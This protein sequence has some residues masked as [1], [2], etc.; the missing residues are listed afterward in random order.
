MPTLDLRSPAFDEGAAIPSRFTCDGEDT[1]PPL[2]ASPGPQ[3]TESY[4]LVFDDPDAPGGTWVHW[5]VWNLTTP[6]LPE[7]ASGAALP[8]G[9]VEGT[10]SWGRQGY[11]GPCPPSGTHRYFFRMYALDTRL[12]LPPE[13]DVHALRKAM[14]GHVLAEGEWMGTYCRRRN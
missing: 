11:G 14:E 5:L 2:Q 3:G 12:S 6:S 10:N 1:S 8:E 9:A 13:A 7:G 4:A